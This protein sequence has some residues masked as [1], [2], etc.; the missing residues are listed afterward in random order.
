MVSCGTCGRS[1]SDSLIVGIAPGISDDSRMIPF[2]IAHRQLPEPLRTPNEEPHP[3]I[4]IGLGAKQTCHSR[5]I[6]ALYFLER[7]LF[8][9]RYC[10]RG[11]IGLCER[12]GQI[13]QQEQGS[14]GV[15]TP[16]G[17]ATISWSALIVSSGTAQERLRY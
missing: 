12:L 7:G 8:R 16:G 15:L 1:R 9:C 13:G 10:C 6:A 4:R 2:A 5:T 3:I 14:C 11:C 17:L